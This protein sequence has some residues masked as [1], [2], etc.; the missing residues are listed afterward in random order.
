MIYRRSCPK[1]T[2]RTSKHFAYDEERRVIWEAIEGGSKVY[3][4]SYHLNPSEPGFGQPN[5]WYSRTVETRPD[6]STFTVYANRASGTLLT[7]LDDG[8]GGVWYRNTRYNSSG[9]RIYTAEPSAIASVSEP[10]GMSTS[11]SVNLKPDSGL[12][13]VNV[14]Y[15]ATDPELG[16]VKGYLEST[17]IKEGD[18]GDYIELRRY[19]YDTHTVNGVSIHPRASEETFPEIGQPGNVTRYRRCWYDS[20]DEETGYF[21]DI[22]RYPGNEAE[23]NDLIVVEQWQNTWNEASQIILNTHW[24]RF[25]D[26]PDEQTGAL[27]G[28][29]GEQPKGR[30]AYTAQWY[31]G[32]GR[33]VASADYGT[34][35]GSSSEERR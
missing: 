1:S 25:E 29:T 23:V 16:A 18:Q 27:Q 7:K 3:S 19:T 4:F 20:E 11:L 9:R 35:G 32:I 14:W 17:G 28:P 10:S 22:T 2:E 5:V 30:R 33:G 26:A 15:A 12:L 21:G 31:D 6:G 13:H 34:N 8:Q 24:Q